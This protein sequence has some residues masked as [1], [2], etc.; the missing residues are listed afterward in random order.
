MKKL[1]FILA[2]LFTFSF[3]AQAQEGIKLGLKAGVNY[4][5]LSGDGTDELDSQFGFHVGGFLDYGIS[6]MVSIRPELLFS[7]KGFAVSGDDDDDFNQSLR[8]IDLPI[9]VRVNAGGLYFEGGPTL[10]YLVSVSEGETDDY[11]KFEFGYAAGLGYQMASG[12]GIGL[13]Y[14]GG[15]T[16]IIDNDDADKITNSVFQLGLSY[17]LGTR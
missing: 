17:T 3:A 4:S 6:E 14:Q 2:A 7:S 10:G 8:Y 11:K 5:N 15:L 1:V 9:M 16:S 13:R 12:L